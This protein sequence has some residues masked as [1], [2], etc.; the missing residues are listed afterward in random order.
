MQQNNRYRKIRMMSTAM[1]DLILL[2]LFFCLDTSAAAMQDKQV[3]GGRGNPV[4]SPSRRTRPRPKPDRPKGAQKKS[5]QTSISSSTIEPRIP[6]SSSEPDTVPF[7][8]LPRSLAVFLEPKLRARVEYDTVGEAPIFT[9][10]DASEGQLGLGERRI[11]IPATGCSGWLNLNPDPTKPRLLA[12]GWFNLDGEVI[13]EVEDGK[14]YGTFKDGPGTKNELDIRYVKR[15]RFKSAG[16]AVNVIFRIGDLWSLAI[17]RNKTDMTITYQILRGDRWE[18]FSLDP[19]IE[20]RHEW[21]NDDAPTI[22]YEPSGKHGFTLRP[23]YPS[24]T[25]VLDLTPQVGPKPDD[26]ENDKARIHVFQLDSNGNIELKA[27]AK[28]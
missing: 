2:L 1:R 15:L 8:P 18:S 23:G 21:L 10:E 26:R 11:S 22:K 5:D 19:G 6:S 16:E 20:I 17:L 24:K 27:G 3:Q 13:V 4:T 25:Q 12:S 7:V 28:P 14:G 9:C